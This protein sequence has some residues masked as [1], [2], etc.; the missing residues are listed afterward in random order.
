[1]GVGEQKHSVHDSVKD[2][3]GKLIQV[4]AEPASWGTENGGTLLTGFS[5]AVP[6]ER[7]YVNVRKT[8]MEV[9]PGSYKRAT[10]TCVFYPER[11]I[12]K[13]ILLI[14]P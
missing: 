5:A 1:M 6:P 13:Y 10:C 4:V 14:N 11:K 9:S 2:C 8:G 7:A 12:K 3:V